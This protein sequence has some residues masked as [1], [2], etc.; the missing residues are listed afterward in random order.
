MMRDEID[1]ARVVLEIFR[2]CGLSKLEVICFCY[3]MDMFYAPALAGRKWSRVFRPLTSFGASIIGVD[4]V[5]DFTWDKEFG[6]GP[7]DFWFQGELAVMAADR[8]WLKKKLL[9]SSKGTGHI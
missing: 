2:S 6:D 9:S 5:R 4:V 3:T 1:Y 7:G 8:E